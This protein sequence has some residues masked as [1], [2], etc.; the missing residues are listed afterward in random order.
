MPPSPRPTTST[1]SPAEL[2]QPWLDRYGGKISS[3]WF[4]PKALQILRE[5]PDVYRAADRLIEAADWVVWQ[6]TGV[7]TRNNCTAGYK[8]LW[9][10]DDGFPATPFFE[11]L[12]PGFGSV[13]DD[14][15]S[16]IDRPARRGRRRP[17]RAGRR[18]DGPPPGIAVAVANVD[19]HVSVPAAA[20]HRARHAG[21]DHGHEHLPRRARRR[22]AG[23]PGHVRGRRGRGRS[24]ACIGYE[25]GQAAVGD[26]FG[27]FV[28]HGV[29]PALPRGRAR[30]AGSA[31]MRSSPKPPRRCGPASPGSSRSTGGTATGPS[32]SMPTCR[33]CSSGMTLATEAPA[34]YRALIEATAFGTR[35]IVDA[36][37]AG[38]VAVDE[39]VACGGLPDRNPLLMQ[40]YADVTG[41]TWRVAA[42]SQT[43]GARRRRCSRRSR[44]ARPPV[45]TRRSSAA[46]AAM[47]HL[48][49]D[50]Y[51]PDRGAPAR[52][53]TS[54]TREYV[55]LHDLF[56]RGGDP[57]MKTLKRLRASRRSRWPRLA[58]P[59]HA[60]AADEDQ[61]RGRRA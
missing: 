20:R 53:T 38:G 21:R 27:W 40:I 3:E 41:R 13:V 49:D 32:S 5:A 22:G 48:R 55:R 16:R 39:V 54:S 34:I 12:D 18:L 59:A 47:A 17:E 29:P 52:S 61:A 51:E 2:D 60:A 10:A 11:A 8:A 7:E 9:S 28:E 19:A 1:G 44:P 33:A 46:A 43:P 56:G 42:S 37:E 25:A 23:G 35:V 26:L 31:S 24:R 50:V 45:A 15:M 36:F 4:F 58:R 57:A 14:K 30:D 6:L